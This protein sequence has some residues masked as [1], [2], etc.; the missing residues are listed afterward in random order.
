MGI[1]PSLSKHNLCLQCRGP[2]NPQRW[3]FSIGRNLVEPYNFCSAC[4]LRIESHET[5]EQAKIAQVTYNL[6]E[7]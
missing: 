1:F 6:L 2:V 5:R 4:G 7:G 3:Y